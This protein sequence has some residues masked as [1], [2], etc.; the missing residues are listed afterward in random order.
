MVYLYAD[1]VR[2][3]TD[4]IILC[5]HR[6]FLFPKLKDEEKKPVASRMA[7]GICNNFGKSALDL[8]N[9]S[10]YHCFIIITTRHTCPQLSTGAS[11]IDLRTAYRLYTRTHVHESVVHYNRKTKREREKARKVYT[12]Y[13]N[14]QPT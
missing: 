4:F 3:S 6:R 14:V 13:K 8:F 12:Y 7:F 10:M 5:F 11:P 9:D 1:S 2:V